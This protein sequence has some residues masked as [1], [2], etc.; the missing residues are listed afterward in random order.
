MTTETEKCRH[1]GSIYE[2]CDYCNRDHEAEKKIED[3]FE[4]ISRGVNGGWGDVKGKLAELIA[5]EHPTLSGQIAKAVAIGIM[6]RAVYDPAWKP[7]DKYDRYCTNPQPTNLIF[8]DGTGVTMPQHADHDGRFSCEL[9]IGAE[10]M[11]RQWY[12]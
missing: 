5:N 12:V 4:I 10:L 3:A 1:G 6:H 9:V 2:R 11:A 8:G 7:Y